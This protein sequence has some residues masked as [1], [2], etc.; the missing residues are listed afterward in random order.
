MPHEP[1]VF[2]SRDYR[3]GLTLGQAQ[4]RTLLRFTRTAGAKETGG[5]L[6]GRYSEELDLAY[7]TQVSAPPRD[8]KAGGYS[9]ERGYQ[10]LQAWLLKLWRAPEP[11]YYLGEWHFH[12]YASPEASGPDREQMRSIAASASYACP[13]PVLLILGGDPKGAWDV[14]AYVFPQ[15]AEVVPLCRMPT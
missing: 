11:T 4:V 8:S 10:G 6:V 15:R 1:L 14:R 5:V 9:F 3:F 2:R 7:I 13:E 12:P